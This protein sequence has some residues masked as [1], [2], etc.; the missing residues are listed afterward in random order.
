M[1]T[2]SPIRQNHESTNDR[3]AGQPM[4]TSLMMLVAIASGALP[5]MA[6]G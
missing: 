4:K 1:I 2:A 6:A 5:M 3:I